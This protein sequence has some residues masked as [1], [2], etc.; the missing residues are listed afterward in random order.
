MSLMGHPGSS[1]VKI[2]MLVLNTYGVGRELE[3]RSYDDAIS[4]LE[5]AARAGWIELKY[6]RKSS[7]EA[8]PQAEDIIPRP[9]SSMGNCDIPVNLPIN[10]VRGGR[11]SQV[12]GFQ[13]HCQ[14]QTDFLPA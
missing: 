13:D 12:P 1:P 11:I 9:L 14:I 10:L 8:L 2:R 7:F 6:V 4:Q 3:A 5:A